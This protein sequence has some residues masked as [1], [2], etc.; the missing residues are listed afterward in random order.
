[1]TTENVRRQKL[2]GLLERGKLTRLTILESDYLSVS[3]IRYKENHTA[4]GHGQKK[5][6]LPGG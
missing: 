2:L 6:R 5:D 1:M 3:G 4:A